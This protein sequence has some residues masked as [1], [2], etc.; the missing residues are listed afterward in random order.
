MELSNSTVKTPEAETEA[1]TQTRVQLPAAKQ[2]PFRNSVLKRHAPP[3]LHH[4]VVV[5]Y[6]ECLKNH[7]AAIGGHAIDG[8]CEF[9][10]SPASNPVDPTSLKC[11]A[12]GCHRNFHRREPEVAVRPPRREK[13]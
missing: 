1:P 8:C 2:S 6:R 10:P 9:M 3:Q 12:C 13:W 5:T 4:P 11:A 7:A